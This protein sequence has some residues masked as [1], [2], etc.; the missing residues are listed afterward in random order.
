MAAKILDG[1]ATAESLRQEQAQRVAALQA[2]GIT[3]GLAVVLVGENPASQ[4]Y[5]RNKERACQAV[6]IYSEVHR[7]PQ[8]TSQ[9]ELLGLIARLNADPKIHGVLVQLPLPEKLDEEQVI[10]AIRPDKDVD[11]FHPE[12]AGKLLL[13]QE[14]F[15]PC[16]PRGIL[17]LL[18]RAGIP[19]AGREVV[20]VGR[21]NIVGKPAGL[22]LL[23]QNATVSVCHSRTANLA[24]HTRRADIL[25]VA[26]GKPG[27]ITADM[28]RPGAVVV[29]V[30]INRVGDRLV[31]DVDFEGVSQVAGWIT[32]VP[33]GVGPMT[34]SMLLENTLEAAERLASA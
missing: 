21:S 8:S 19:V 26:V 3:P 28:V 10:L 27:F 30:G 32:P 16:T 20:V 29:D 13:G 24:E 9:Q 31:G 5:V 33:G 1:K 4:T 2:R 17:V 18:E 25:V 6:G 15:I 23:A 34:I 7:L 14:A 11:G 22:L 12:N